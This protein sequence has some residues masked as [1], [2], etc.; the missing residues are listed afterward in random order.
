M[1]DSLQL[2]YVIQCDTLQLQLVGSRLGKITFIQ[3]PHDPVLLGG[4]VG[5]EGVGDSTGVTHVFSSLPWS[6]SLNLL[7][8]YCSSLI[9]FVVFANYSLFLL[10]PAADLAGSAGD[11]GGVGVEGGEEQEILG[12]RER[13]ESLLSGLPPDMLL[14]MYRALRQV[15]QGK[16]CD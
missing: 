3:F 12:V 6:G 4:G 10:F 14:G 5:R 7:E 16:T 1:C 8:T 2:T 11:G 9:V 13:E 15:H